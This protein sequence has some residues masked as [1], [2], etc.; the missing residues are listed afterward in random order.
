VAEPGIIRRMPVKQAVPADAVVSASGS[1]GNAIWMIVHGLQE[2]GLP[3]WHMTILPINQHTWKR[4]YALPADG[5]RGITD[6]MEFD[7]FHI[8]GPGSKHFYYTEH[9]QPL[10]VSQSGGKSRPWNDVDWD[11]ANRIVAWKFRQ[12]EYQFAYEWLSTYVRERPAQERTEAQYRKAAEAH[13]NNQNNV[14]R[15]YNNLA[16]ANGTADLPDFHVWA[17]QMESAFQGTTAE[18]WEYVAGQVKQST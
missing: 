9:L 14:W 18:F 13:Q 3:Q 4:A 6:W 8:T 2:M 17:Q 1:Q 12:Q 7:E 10:A 16:K 5:K 11:N 15:L